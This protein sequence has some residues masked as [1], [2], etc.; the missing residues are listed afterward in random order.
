MG[1]R[2]VS[3]SSRSKL[4]LKMNYLVI[5]REEEIKRVYLDEISVLIIDRRC[6]L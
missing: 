4:E 5:R 6:L 3:V 2:V 1:W